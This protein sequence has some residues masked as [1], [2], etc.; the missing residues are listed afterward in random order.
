MNCIREK[1]GNCFLNQVVNLL[2]L[3]R[4]SLDLDLCC[5]NFESYP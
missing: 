4:L 3:R 2:D 5:L 1:V